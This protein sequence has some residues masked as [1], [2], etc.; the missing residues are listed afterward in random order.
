MFPYFLEILANKGCLTTYKKM[1]LVF[2]IYYS[3]NDIKK[4]AYI[5]RFLQQFCLIFFVLF[6]NGSFSWGGVPSAM[7]IF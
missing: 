4:K 5:Y 1:I 7:A 3:T 6:E 2:F